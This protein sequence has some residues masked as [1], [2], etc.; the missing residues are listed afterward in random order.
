MPL[1]VNRISMVR[2]ISYEPAIGPLRIGLHDKLEM[3]NWI[4][5]GG[6]SGPDARMMAI[7]LA[8][9]SKIL[10]PLRVG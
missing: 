8:F 7:F 4:I 2:F 9:V 6:E 10:R 5:C 3:P 1:G